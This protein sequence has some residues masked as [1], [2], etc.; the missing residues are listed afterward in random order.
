M[1]LVEEAVEGSWIGHQA[2]MSALESDIGSVYAPPKALGAASDHVE[3][4]VDIGRRPGGWQVKCEKG[5]I[6]RVLMNIFGNSL[7]F[8]SVCAGSS[9]D[10]G[11]D[12]HSCV[13]TERVHP[14]LLARGRCG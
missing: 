14:R 6:R 1:Q 13:L 3:T 5:G 12:G 8:T 2:R 9:L 7:K 4:V 11:R 10:I